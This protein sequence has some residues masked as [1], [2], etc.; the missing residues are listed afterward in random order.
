MAYKTLI[1]MS[2]Y[3]LVYGKP[4]HLP[5]K[6]EH[7]AFWVVKQCN[8]NLGAAGDQ[9]KVQLNELEEIRNDAYESS[10][11]YKEKT[12]AYHDKMISRKAFVVGQKVILFHSC[13]KL[14]PGK[15]HSR[16]IGPF[17]VA[18]VFPH[19]AVEI[20]SLQT[21]KEFKLCYL[22][23]YIEPEYLSKPKDSIE[24]CSAATYFLANLMDAPLPPPI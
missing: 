22:F 13:L 6:L 7:K 10:R 8:M 21:E 20:K 12:K 17:V 24:G 16:W 19:G 1:G 15:L 11:I 5:V 14:F 18:N 2:P 4:C 9:R 3:R 23:P